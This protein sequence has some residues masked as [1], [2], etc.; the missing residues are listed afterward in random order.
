MHIVA[1]GIEVV[2]ELSDEIIEGGGKIGGSCTTAA[3]AHDHTASQLIKTICDGTRNGVELHPVE[4]KERDQ[5][6]LDGKPESGAAI[7]RP[8]LQDHVYEEAN[9]G[10][11]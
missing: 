4:R 2:S 6:E 3:K 8:H 9:D 11:G 7:N 10:E 5:H 1:R